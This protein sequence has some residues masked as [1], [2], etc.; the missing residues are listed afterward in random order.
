MNL[1]WAIISTRIDRDYFKRVYHR[2]KCVK[3]QLSEGE[4]Q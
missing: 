4:G 3:E 1:I 2:W